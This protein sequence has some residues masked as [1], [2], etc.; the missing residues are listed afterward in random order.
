MKIHI[1][2]NIIVFELN[3]EDYIIQHLTV[4]KHN[5]YSFI[6]KKSS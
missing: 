2:M 6:T 5:I 1:T 3:S 4:Q